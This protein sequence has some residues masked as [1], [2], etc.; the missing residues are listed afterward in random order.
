MRREP[1]FIRRMGRGH[2][3]YRRDG[4]LNDDLGPV[5]ESNRREDAKKS[6]HAA[7]FEMVHLL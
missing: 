5:C 2:G 7:L 6:L 4:F 1:L 3:R